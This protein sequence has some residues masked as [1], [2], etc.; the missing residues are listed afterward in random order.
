[1]NWYMRDLT[2]EQYPFPRRGELDTL[3]YAAAR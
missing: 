3:R 2:V 1:M